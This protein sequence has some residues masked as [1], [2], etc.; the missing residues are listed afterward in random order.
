MSLVGSRPPLPTEVARGCGR[1]LA[2]L[3]VLP[4]LTC[5]WQIK[6]RFE[7]PFQ[8][9]V[10]LDLEYIAQQ[11]L[12]LD[13]EILLMKIPVVLLLEETPKVGTRSFGQAQVPPNCVQGNDISGL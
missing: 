3:N 7:L 5:L 1:E 13:L 8:E 4:G 12:W 10:L 6:G 11:T 9:Q 2:R